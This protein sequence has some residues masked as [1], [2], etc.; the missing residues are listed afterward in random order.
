MSEPVIAH[1]EHSDSSRESSPGATAQEMLDKPAIGQFGGEPEPQSS[2]PAKKNWRPPSK[3]FFKP[4]EECVQDEEG[5]M[6][7]D[8]SRQTFF[9]KMAAKDQV[10]ASVRETVRSRF[11]CLACGRPRAARPRAQS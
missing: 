5:G 2:R 9:E 1:V 7:T 10:P 8:A 6:E 11:A 3:W 4:T